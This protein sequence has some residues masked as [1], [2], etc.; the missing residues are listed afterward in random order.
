MIRLIPFLLLTACVSA[1]IAPNLK[2]PEPAKECPKLALPPVPNEAHLTIR[3]NEITADEGG[4]VL[5][6]GYVHA[7]TLLR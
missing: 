1:P 6:R 4:A 7:R 5:L 2:L 3:G